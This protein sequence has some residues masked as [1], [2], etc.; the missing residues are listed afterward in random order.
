VIKEFKNWFRLKKKLRK[1]LKNPIK[2]RPI[3]PCSY[4]ETSYFF[5]N[6]KKY[7]NTL[8]A[9]IAIKIDKKLKEIN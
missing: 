6:L 3:N 1:I 4:I 5:P 2:I 9:Q 7:K 8:P